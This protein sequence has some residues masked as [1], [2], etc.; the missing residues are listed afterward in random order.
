MRRNRAMCAMVVAGLLSWAMLPMGAARLAEA[1]SGACAGNLVGK[2]FTCE[3]VGQ[4]EADP[5][6]W[7]FVPPEP[8]LGDFQLNITLLSAGPGGG[9]PPC[10]N[11]GGFPQALGCS[12]RPTGNIN[13]PRFD[14]D[15]HAFLCTGVIPFAIGPIAIVGRL[16]GPQA[17]QGDGVFLGTDGEGGGE[18]FFFACQQVQ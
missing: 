6:C 15:Q 12:C 10:P 17:L 8:D 1:Q 14:Q 7:Q 2:T 16:A 5:L 4:G 9:T 11:P 13:N 3:V 18:S